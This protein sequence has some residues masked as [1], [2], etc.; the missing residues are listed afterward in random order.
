M[1]IVIRRAYDEPRDDDG[2]RVLVDRLW[3]RGLRKDGAAI[4]AWPKDAAP[5]TELRHWFHEHGDFAAFAERYR[6]ELEAGEAGAALAATLAPHE[7]VTFLTALR[8]VEPSHASVLRDWIA[9]R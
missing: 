3:P 4:D 9:A 7:H 2:L 1:A 5:S 6:D 8:E